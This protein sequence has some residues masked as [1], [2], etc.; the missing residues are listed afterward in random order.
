MLENLKDENQN[1]IN[2]VTQQTVECQAE[3]ATEEKIDKAERSDKAEKKKVKELEKKLAECEK[4]LEAKN[5]EVA[6]TNDKYLRIMAEYDN[7]RKRSVKEKEGIYADAYADALKSLLPIIDTLEKASGYK[8]AESVSKGVEMILAGAK[9]ALSKM[10]VESF[11][12]K[13]EAFDPNRH[14]AIMHVEDENL[15]EGVVADVYQKGYVK[16]DKILRYAMVTVAN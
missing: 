12:E 16:G 2:E 4:Q 6:T 13:G 11:G 1:D 15:G 7:F 3:E 5:A 8:D 10:G 9:D 14:N